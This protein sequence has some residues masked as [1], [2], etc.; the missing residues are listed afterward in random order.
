MK[1]ALALCYA[2]VSIMLMLG[3]SFAISLHR[4]L[5][6]TGLS[7]GTVLFIGTGFMLKARARRRAA[8]AE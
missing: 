6:A 7:V 5:L 4:P 8:T 3:I 2:I 1:P